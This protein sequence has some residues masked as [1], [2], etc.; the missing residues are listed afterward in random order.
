MGVCAADT[1]GSLCGNPAGPHG[2]VF[3]ANPVFSEF[4]VGGLI[5]YPIRIGLGV[6]KGRH[7]FQLSSYGFHLFDGSK[8]FQSSQIKSPPL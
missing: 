1:P 8:M 4:A 7:L 6:H 2:A 3:A 5:F